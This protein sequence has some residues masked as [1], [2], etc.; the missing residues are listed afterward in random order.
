MT[1]ETRQHESDEQ[2]MH[3]QELASGATAQGML[4]PLVSKSV[5][6]TL[7]QRL[8]TP[9]VHR[10]MRSTPVQ[11][12]VAELTIHL[13]DVDLAAAW[14]LCERWRAQGGPVDELVTLVLCGSAHQLGLQWVEDQIDFATCTAAMTTLGILLRRVEHDM[15]GRQVV[16]RR[17]SR[18]LILPVPGDSHSFGSQVVAFYLR[19]RGFAVRTGV[20]AT[21]D[22]ALFLAGQAP[23]DAIGFSVAAQESLPVLAQTVRMLKADTDTAR[24]PIF[25]GGS[26]V[27]SAPETVRRL[28]VDL[29]L[30][31]IALAPGALT[32]LLAP[33][34]VDVA[35]SS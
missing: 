1:P 14:R 9:N 13:I 16:P 17:R 31:D 3:S 32:R 5:L 12:H 11:A 7:S 29:I 28:N 15:G 19:R 26:L 4:V 23:I 6:P 33:V 18:L 27:H 10:K 24:L 25:V 22:E 2:A 35:L 20:A 30:A 21:P 8:L 34:A